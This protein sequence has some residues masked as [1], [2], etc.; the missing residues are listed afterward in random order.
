M[1]FL[2]SFAVLQYTTRY[3]WYVLALQGT[4]IGGTLVRSH[5][6]YWYVRYSLVQ[7]GM[8]HTGN[9]SV[10]R[11]GLVRQTILFYIGECSKIFDV[12]VCLQCLFNHL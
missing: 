12:C 4:G 1:F 11:Y 7:F 3:G 6:L 2:P 8:Y 9:W 5:V 10:Y